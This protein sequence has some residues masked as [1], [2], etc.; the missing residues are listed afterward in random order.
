MLSNMYD[1]STEL[2]SAIF[3]AYSLP[4]AINLRSIL[5]KINPLVSGPSILCLCSE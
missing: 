4:Y 3:L 2:Y 5:A 1:C